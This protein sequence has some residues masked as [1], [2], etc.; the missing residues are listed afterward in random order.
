MQFVSRVLV[1]PA[2]ALSLVS[3]AHAQTKVA[4]GYTAIAD[5]VALYAAKEEGYF[6]KRGLHVEPTLVTL[7]SIIP[8]ALLSNSLQVGLPTPSVFLQAADAG[9]DLVIIGG[10]SVT[11]PSTLKN[12]G[13]VVRTG[14]NIR[15]AQGF[16]GKKV[17]VPG[18]GAFL[19]VIFRQWLIQN[20]VDPKRVTYVE[21][22]FPVMN[23]VL[24]A[25]TVDAVVSAA[26][27]MMRIIGAG[28][29]TLLP[30]YA[31]S[32]PNGQSASFFA[33]TREW[34]AKNLAI[35]KAFQNAIVEGAAFAT[36]N[37]DRASEYIAKYTK[38]PLEIVKTIPLPV[39]QPTVTDAQVAWWVEVMQ[40]QDMLRT[41]IDVSKLVVR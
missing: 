2:L 5:Y 14:G 35:V 39:L 28:T 38:L 12:F 21:V 32:L 1:L 7:N 33:T 22:G 24:R 9:I 41:K 34:A 11:D 37:P 25:G 20:G 40:K 36:A 26:P 23:D 18:L 15:N 30:G 13:V 17:G 16:V 19:H 31:E 4:V 29:G 27:I 10:S 3:G 8:Q 6:V